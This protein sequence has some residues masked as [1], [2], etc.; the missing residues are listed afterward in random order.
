MAK[1]QIGQQRVDVGKHGDLTLHDQLDTYKCERT[2]RIT[3]KYMKHAN[4]IVG[5]SREFTAKTLPDEVKILFNMVV[6]E[7]HLVTV[8]FRYS[9]TYVDSTTSKNK[10]I[11]IGVYDD[12]EEA[13]K[14]G[15]KILEKM[16]SRYKLHIFPSKGPAK[17][18][19]FSKNGG[20]F[21]SKKNLI[22]NMTY[23]TTPFQFFAKITTLKYDSIDEAID[24]VEAA[25]KRYD[26]YIE[27][28]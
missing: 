19:R 4:L 14:E 23:L 10:E 9:D 3:F 26:K 27:E 28:F 16:E 25:S 22:T 21:G 5:N 2:G 18:E 17:K 13:C 24:E 20:P 1:I 6:K 7:K 15:N 11:T 8:E 12:F